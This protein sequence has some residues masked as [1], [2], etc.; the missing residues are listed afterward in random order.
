MDFTLTHTCYGRSNLHPIGQLTHM[1]KPDGDPEPDGVLYRTE[2]IHYRQVYLNI[3]DPIVFIPLAVDTSVRIYDDF[4]RLLFL[5]AHSETSTLTNK[6][7]GIGI[8]ILFDLS[9][10]PFIPLPCFIRSSRQTP[11]LD[12]SLVFFPPRLSAFILIV[13]L[14]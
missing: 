5:H 10:R 2:I 9:S 7:G 11:F 4:N 3:P 6:L 1:R 8:S 12:P 14:M 13:V